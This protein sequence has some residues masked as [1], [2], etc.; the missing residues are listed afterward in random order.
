[1]YLPRIRKSAL[2]RTVDFLFLD[3]IL[4]LAHPEEGKVFCADER[5]GQGRSQAEA[6]GEVDVLALGTREQKPTKKVR[7]KH[8]KS[9]KRGQERRMESR[10]GIH[11]ATK[12]LFVCLGE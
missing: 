12:M 2:H 6:S 9:R 4:F 8:T 5:H 3:S 10:F 7:N 11:F 1:M